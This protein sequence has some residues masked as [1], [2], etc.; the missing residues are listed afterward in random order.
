MGMQVGVTSVKLQIDEAHQIISIGV[1]A[2]RRNDGEK[3]AVS[4][5][6]VSVG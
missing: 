2:A 6:E 1:G 5:R 4:E 3:R